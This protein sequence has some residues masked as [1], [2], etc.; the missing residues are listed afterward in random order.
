[1]QS[2]V[3][4][5]TVDDK[6]MTTTPRELPSDSLFRIVTNTIVNCKQS[7]IKIRISPDLYFLYRDYAFM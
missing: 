1:M 3:I 7:R 4:T 5:A 2:L 6:V